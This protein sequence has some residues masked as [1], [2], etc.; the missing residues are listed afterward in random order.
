MP[1]SAEHHLALDD[2]LF[3]TLE[4]GAPATLRIWESPVTVVV[5]GRSGAIARDV[6]EAACAADGVDIL[7]RGSGGGAVLLGP[8]C[9]NYSLLLSLEKHA[10]LRDVCASYGRILGFVMRA[11]AVPGLEIRGLSD[12]ALEDRKVSGNAQRRGSRALLHHGTLLCGLDARLA[13]RYLKEP[14]RQPEYR[15]GRYH[16]EFIGRLPL[17]ARQIEGRL[18]QSGAFDIWTG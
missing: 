17:S 14:H 15:Q 6:D 18:R 9:V 3:Q 4:A 12:L 1:A 10:E 2:A 5:L 13:A 11:L 7:R 16:E 8:G